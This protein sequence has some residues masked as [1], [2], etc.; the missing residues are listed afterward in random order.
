MLETISSHVVAM[1]MFDSFRSG[2]IPSLEG[3]A[4][5]WNRE[6]RPTRPEHAPIHITQGTEDSK[7]RKKDSVQRNVTSN[8]R[9]SFNQLVS[10]RAALHRKDYIEEES[11]AAWYS[12]AETGRIFDEAKKIVKKINGG[13]PLN[14][15]ESLSLRGLECRTNRENRKKT[16][17]RR[18]A[19]MVV[20]DEQERHWKT[21]IE[22]PESLA[23]AYSSISIQAQNEA[24]RRGRLDEVAAMMM[25]RT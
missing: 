1:P 8:R 16:E 9:V 2:G 14:E 24:K 21:G 6:M 12:Q 5:S 18:L 11:R 10:V 23:I 22:S 25:N 15:Q 3:C 19:R 4:N 7:L 20:R 13:L 17:M